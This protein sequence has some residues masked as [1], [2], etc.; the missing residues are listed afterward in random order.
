MSWALCHPLE[1]AKSSGGTL[2]AE[3]G[4]VGGEEEDNFGEEDNFDEEEDHFGEEE[5][6]L[7]TETKPKIFANAV[8]FK[9]II[10]ILFSLISEKSH[11][12]V[13]QHGHDRCQPRRTPT[14]CVLLCWSSIESVVNFYQNTCFLVFSSIH[15]RLESEIHKR[16]PSE[17]FL[18]S[19]VTVIMPVY[20]GYF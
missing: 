4:C 19:F 6:H 7:P 18:M 9:M 3:G 20:W 17:K 11:G 16:R 10:I 12:K 15:N 2:R 1:T 14:M 8:A 13:H 5:D